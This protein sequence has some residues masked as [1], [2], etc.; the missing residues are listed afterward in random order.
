[1]KVF[2]QAYDSE[3]NRLKGPEYHECMIKCSDYKL[4]RNYEFAKRV[5]REGLSINGVV[6]SF[7]VVNS[8]DE[9]LEIIR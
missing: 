8:K 4:S 9:I 5:V 6:K 1:M 2:L 3:G 7:K